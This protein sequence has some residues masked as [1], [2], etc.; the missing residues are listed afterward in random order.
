MVRESEEMITQKDLQDAMD[1][2]GVKPEQIGLIK[3]VKPAIP[4][5]VKIEG[6]GDFILKVGSF[7]IPIHVDSAMPEDTILMMPKELL[8]AIV[9]I[10]N[11]RT[12]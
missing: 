5:T 8:E 2:A 4:G 3:N 6:S 9:E 7:E 10:K 1:A 11:R 12:K